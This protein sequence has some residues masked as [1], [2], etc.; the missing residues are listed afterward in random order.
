M[1]CLKNK[2]SVFVYVSHKPLISSYNIKYIDAYPNYYVKTKTVL[3]LF[4]YKKI[5]S[6]NV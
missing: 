1:R 6:E 3:E 4:H 5:P 2:L